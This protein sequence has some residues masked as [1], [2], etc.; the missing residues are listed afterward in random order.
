[1][2]FIIFKDQKAFQ[3]K[4]AFNASRL[5]ALFGNGLNLRKWTDIITDL[6]DVK[7]K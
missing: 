7:K 5:M 6:I 1:M 4:N 3:N 2:I